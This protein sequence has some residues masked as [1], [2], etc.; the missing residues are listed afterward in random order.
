M[1]ECL[2]NIIKHRQKPFEYF[3]SSHIFIDTIPNAN[4]SLSKQNVTVTTCIEKSPR[5]SY[6]FHRK[7]L[8]FPQKAAKRNFQ[9]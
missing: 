9:K 6:E 2:K 1:F 4:M 8:G 3:F 5:K 7:I